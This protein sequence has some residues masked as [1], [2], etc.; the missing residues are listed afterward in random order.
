M[1]AYLLESSHRTEQVPGLAT[2]L[3]FDSH[4]IL[5]DETYFLEDC[6]TLHLIEWSIA[7]PRRRQGASKFSHDGM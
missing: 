4:G 6:P 7:V 5:R 3:I 1:L 2:F